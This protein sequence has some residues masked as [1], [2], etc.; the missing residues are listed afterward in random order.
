MMQ[1]RSW[2]PKINQAAHPLPSKP[3]FLASSPQ[4]A[5]PGA[6]HMET[7]DR[8]RTEVRRHPVITVMPRDHRAQPAT[9]L[10]HWIVQPLAQFH[11]DFL[12]L[13]AFPLTHRA[14]PNRELPLSRLATDMREAKKVEGL[15]L[16]LSTCLSILDG[17]ASK[18]DDPRFLGM[19]FQFELGE[20]FR[21]LMM[22]LL[23]VRLVRKTHHEV[24]SPADN[25][26][27]ALALVL[28]QCCTQRS[29]T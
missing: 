9:H 21:Q 29:N 18:L 17:K 20:A 2:K 7:K 15:R 16:P 3:R 23:G 22:K 5:I 13:S 4:R 12:Q 14:P 27:V 11:L 10:R 6:S 26:N 25:D 1:Y 19:Q 8:Q 24:I 28:R